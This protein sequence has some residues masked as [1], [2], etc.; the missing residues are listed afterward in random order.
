[1]VVGCLPVPKAW[2]GSM[3]MVRGSSGVSCSGVQGWMV[4]EGMGLKGDP[5]LKFS[6]GD[7]GLFGPVNHAADL[8]EQGVQAIFPGR[9]DYYPS[10]FRGQGMAWGNPSDRGGKFFNLC[11]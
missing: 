4:R 1:M 7:E 3:M 11:G 5:H 6:A 9:H 2:M 8:H 10:L